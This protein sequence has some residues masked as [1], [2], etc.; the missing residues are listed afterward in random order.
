MPPGPFWVNSHR[1]LDPI[2]TPV[3]SN[4]EMIPGAPHIFSGIYLT[5]DKNDYRSVD[6]FRILERKK[7]QHQKINGRNY[8]ECPNNLV[9]E[10]LF[11]KQISL[12]V[13]FFFYTYTYIYI[14]I[15]VWVVREVD[16]ER[17]ESVEKLVLNSIKTCNCILGAFFYPF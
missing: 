14:Y 5:A 4:N 2:V 16:D 12:V 9:S 3:T 11:K 1:P 6:N 10:G 7:G 15:Y 8:N 13:L 17:D